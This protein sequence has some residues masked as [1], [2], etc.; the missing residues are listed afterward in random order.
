MHNGCNALDLAYDHGH[1][2]VVEFL[3]SKCAKAIN[4]KKVSNALII[5]AIYLYSYKCVTLFVMK[6][7][8][9]HVSMSLFKFEDV[10]FSFWFTYNSETYSK[11]LHWYNRI[12]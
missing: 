10:L 1:C 9:I 11:T 5:L 3:L 12:M 7:T 2:Q 8:I 6:V 4:C